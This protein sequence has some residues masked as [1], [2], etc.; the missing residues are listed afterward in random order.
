MSFSSVK[1]LPLCPHV[2]KE[3][4]PAILSPE[5]V[6]KPE[7]NS[8]IPAIIPTW[9]PSLAEYPKAGFSCYI[10]W[11]C[12]E[13]TTPAHSLQNGDNQV[14]PSSLLQIYKQKLLFN[15]CNSLHKNNPPMVKKKKKEIQIAF[16]DTE[17]LISSCTHPCVHC[18]TKCCIITGSWNKHSVTG[19]ALV[20]GA[21][22]PG[23][24]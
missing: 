9:W 5:Y 8:W 6:A 11:L 7:Q 18:V 21:E 3:R 19:P 2:A 17:H 22:Q 14:S 15:P 23:L 4:S 10:R 24:K 1:V 16:C 13:N 12:N 20:D